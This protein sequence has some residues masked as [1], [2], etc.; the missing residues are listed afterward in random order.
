[1]R[2]W[3]WDDARTRTRSTCTASCSWPAC[4]TSPGSPSSPAEDI[5]RTV[6]A[7]FIH[8]KPHDVLD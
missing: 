8:D 2:G 3:W 7:P 5:S 4:T 1:M 6:S